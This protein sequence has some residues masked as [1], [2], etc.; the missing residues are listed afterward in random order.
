MSFKRRLTPNRFRFAQ[1]AA[2]AAMLFVLLSI[3]MLR[4][5]VTYVSSSKEKVELS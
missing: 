4:V 2:A 3:A 1:I 5:Q